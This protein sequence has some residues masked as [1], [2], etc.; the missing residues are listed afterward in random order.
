MIQLDHL[1]K[2]FGAFTAVDDLCLQVAPGEILAHGSP[3]F[4]GKSQIALSSGHERDTQ[5][6]HGA[7]R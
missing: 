2:R 5:H 3:K 6:H 4:G 1:T 7:R